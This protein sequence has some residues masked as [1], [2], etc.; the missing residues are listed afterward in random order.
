MHILSK[1]DLATYVRD[2]IHSKVHVRGT[3]LIMMFK[4][5]MLYCSP[6]PQT[7]IML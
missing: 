2:L 5:I 4:A 1:K 3:W 7:W 6:L